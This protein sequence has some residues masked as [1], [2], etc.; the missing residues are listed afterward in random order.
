MNELLNF[1]KSHF[2]S[3]R[4]SGIPRVP[5]SWTVSFL[6][7]GGG[8]ISVLFTEFK[9]HLLFHLSKKL[10]KIAIEC[11]ELEIGLL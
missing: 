2:S 10:L 6:R 7:V 9:T 1:F 3:C 11:S 5:N 4:Y 8:G